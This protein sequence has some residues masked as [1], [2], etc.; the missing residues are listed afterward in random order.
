MAS[1]ELDHV[2]HVF[3]LMQGNSPIYD[4]LF[5]DQVLIFTSASKGTVKA[6]L[7][8][9]PKHVNSRKTIHGGITMTMV[10]FFTGL[11]ITTHDLREKSGVSVN[12]N[13]NF[14]GTA[15]VGDIVEI[16]ANADKV[17]KS[18][19]FASFT[20]TKLVDGV[21]GPLIATASQTKYV[22]Q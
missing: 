14:T 20:I 21:P 13:V 5:T 15:G 16:V 9:G 6:Q 7:T 8:L 11:A 4:F 2:K 3:K 1:P 19:A 22:R 10:D 17:G 12:I 18:M